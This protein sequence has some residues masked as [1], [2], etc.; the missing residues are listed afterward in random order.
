[1]SSDKRIVFDLEWNQD[2][3]SNGFDYYGKII[4]PCSS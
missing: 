1:M 4:L 3:K 2:Y